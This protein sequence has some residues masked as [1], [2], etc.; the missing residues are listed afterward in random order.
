MWLLNHEQVAGLTALARRRDLA[1]IGGAL[2]AAFP[3]SRG[4]LGERWDEFVAVGADRAAA[5]G[6]VHMLC[7]AR[8]LAAAIACGAG[9]DSRE[10]WAAAILSDPKRSQGAK[11]FQLGVRVLEQLRSA[12]QPGQPAAADFAAALQQLDVRL[13]AA[14]TLAS[15]LPR[16]RIRLGDACD[17]D[18]IDLRLI[19]A[20]WRQH[21]TAQAGPWRRERCAAAVEAVTLLH[22]PRA[23]AAAQLPAQ[24]TLL[25][26]PADAE[27]IARLRVRVKAAQ[28]CDAQL[29]PLLQWLGPAEPTALR[30]DLAADVT[31][32]VPL[33][34]DT[35]ESSRL[36]FIGEEGSARLSVLTVASCG[37]RASGL[38]LGERST[39]LAAYDAAQHLIAWRREAPAPW[40]LP[41]DA[42][43]AAA[44][45][46]CRR[47]RDGTAVDASAWQ[48]GFRDLDEQLQRGLARLFTGWER[49]AGVGDAAV[50]IDA[51][52]LAGSA[53]ITWG[54]AERPEGIGVPP[55]MRLEGLF[56]LIASRLALRFSGTLAK[57]GSRSRLT[58][59]TEGRSG[60][61]GPWQRGPAD[62]ALGDAVAKLQVAV[63]QSFELEV[64]PIASPALALLTRAGPLRGAIT[65]AVGVGQRPDGPGL[66]WFARLEVQPVVAP[67]R[68]VDPLLGEQHLQQPLLPAQVIVDW[69]LA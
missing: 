38:P 19:D 50:E 40:K 60:L 52:L 6:L 5:A 56:D 53:G 57:A 69:S 15:L 55:Y 64:Q 44:D 30:G 23:D 28:R 35:A 46:R 32:G 39:Q 22:D 26:R 41:A 48:R 33:D 24:I 2:E 65:G 1:R 47:E 21:Y 8:Y 29:H 13:G 12:P 66:R 25:T 18:A 7:V 16:E 58:L 67:L 3:A 31:L 59:S 68:I 43:P 27:G 17:V 36:P 51:A 11:A 20:A 14:G 4:R 62:A 63:Q 42:P 34:A 49:E 37:L 9:F 45:V 61:V 54:W 10:P